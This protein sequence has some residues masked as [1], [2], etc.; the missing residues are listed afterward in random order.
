MDSEMKSPLTVQELC[1]YYPAFRLE[2]V[3]FSLTPGTITGFIGRN[4]AGKT[5]DQGE[6]RL[7]VRGNDLLHPEEAEGDHGRGPELLPGMG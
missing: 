3:S 7:C 4:G 2:D 5:G 6:D 1:K